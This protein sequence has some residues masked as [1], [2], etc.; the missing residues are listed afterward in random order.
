MD[1]L[2]CLQEMFCRFSLGP[3][4][5]RGVSGWQQKNNT[6]FTSVNTVVLTFI[7]WVASGWL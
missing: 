3:H 4:W 7:W 2:D 1:E 6:W 5:G